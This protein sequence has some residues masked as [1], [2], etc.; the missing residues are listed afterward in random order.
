M[1]AT[2]V[3]Q[4]SSIDDNVV[5]EDET[6]VYTVTMSGGRMTGAKS[7]ETAVYV[8]RRADARA[9]V[10][11]M[12]NADISVDKASAPGCKPYYR[13][14][15]SGDLFFD[16]SRICYLPVE[17]TKGKPAK[18]NIERTFRSPEQF[19]RLVLA[20]PYHTV[21]S[22]IEI[23]VPAELAATL[24]VT[25]YKLDSTMTFEKTVAADGAAVYSVRCSE[26]RAYTHEAGAPDYS[27]VVPQLY[28]SGYFK[29]P[30]ELYAHL[31][32]YVP[33]DD[34]GD[35]TVA[36]LAAELQSRA[37]D[38]AVALAD[39]VLSWVHDNIR[40]LGVE[41]GEY[42]IRPALPSEVLAHRA[43]DCKGSAN[44][45]K[46]LL[47][48]CGVDA[49]LVWIGT[50]GHTA[51]DWEEMPALSSGNHMI[52]AAVLPDT[53]LY[54]DGTAATA[55]PGYLPQGIRNRPVMI[56][57]G[58]NVLLARTHDPGITADCD[59]L[60]GSYRI[61]GTDLAGRIEI[62]QRG[63]AR[64]MLLALMRGTTPR[65]REA[66]L[67]EIVKYPKKNVSV[68]GASVTAA[69]DS[70][71]SLL[72][73][74]VVEKASAS[75]AGERILLDLRPLRSTML[76][77]IDTKD[78]TQDY[79]L[80]SPRRNNFCYSVELPEG[81][82]PQRLPEPVA[83]DDRWFKASLSYSYADGVLRCTGFVE[84]VATLVPLAD[85]GERNAT[86]RKIKKAS[87]SRI[88]LIKQ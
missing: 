48:H 68:S 64:A 16:G 46:A 12:Y 47:R 18:V 52:A 87:D 30:Q 57:N 25:P 80:R 66:V 69:G 65:E 2:A 54:L 31:H 82:A 84:P 9:D 23:R 76:N 41:H 60:T 1:L 73:A 7:R 44:L 51:F 53:I 45:T 43:G 32:S 55:A 4:A 8:A 28:I 5:I 50:A 38:D 81:Y 62:H 63:V 10:A 74:D 88:P 59:T 14:W 40:Y 85:I 11:A 78:R 22:N 36:T 24:T 79:E 3:V 86:V 19:C 15:E 17:L 39:T 33:T 72:S 34:P 71:V 27:M 58:D 49:R 13:S 56:E 35:E 37:G 67:E 6:I 42:G 83:V 21:R 26:R 61:E 75:A 20:S 77:V 70:P 29:S